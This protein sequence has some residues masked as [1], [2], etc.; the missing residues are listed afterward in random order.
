LCEA[1]RS[2]NEVDASNPVLEQNQ[3]RVV[4]D[5]TVGP[6]GVGQ[7]MSVTPADIG[8]AR[9]E[10]PPAEQP[11][12]RAELSQHANPPDARWQANTEPSLDE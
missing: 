9:A 11:D 4:I 8:D 3:G 10:P 1:E 5:Y 6:A 7:A 12:H 2:G